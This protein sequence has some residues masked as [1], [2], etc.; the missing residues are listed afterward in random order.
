MSEVKEEIKSH[1]KVSF[2]WL[3]LVTILSL[4]RLR[5]GFLWFWLPGILFLWLGTLAGTFL[6]DIDHLIYWFFTHPE[7][8]DSQQAKKLWQEKEFEKLLL[9]LGQSHD[10][11]TRLIFHSALFQ[12][13]FLIFTLYIFTSG[14][15]FF[16]SGLVAGLNLHLLKDEWEEY[17]EKK[18][19]H[20]ND[21]L[22]W[23]LGR[24]ISFQEQRI[25]LILVSF[26]FILL[27]LLIS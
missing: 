18:Y 27:S 20:L 13:V 16:G 3:I 9:L 12:I 24:K 17:F 26:L 21:W 7:K 25:F 10:T 6:L 15:S 5:A 1:L 22:F 19:N 4:F 11:H 8:E 14:G 2:A 23:Q